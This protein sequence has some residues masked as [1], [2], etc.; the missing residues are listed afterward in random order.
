MLNPTWS[1]NDM[2]RG[3]KLAHAA[4]LPKD[5]P[6]AEHGSQTSPDFLSIG[7]DSGWAEPFQELHKSQPFLTNARWTPNAECEKN[8]ECQGRRACFKFDDVG[9]Q[10][11]GNLR[12]SQQSATGRISCQE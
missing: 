2:D 9:P 6:S 7:S 12:S 8:G 3:R 11:V 5:Y 4:F 1:K 10:G